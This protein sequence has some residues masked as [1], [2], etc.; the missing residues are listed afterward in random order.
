M[1]RKNDRVPAG[2]F[3]Q[4]IAGDSPSPVATPGAACVN[5]TGMSPPSGKPATVSVIAGAAGA[6]PRCPPGLCAAIG[7]YGSS[8]IMQ[9][10]NPSVGLISTLLR[11]SGWHRGACRCNEYR[12]RPRSDSRLDAVAPRLTS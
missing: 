7:A 5:F 4:L 8:V 9:I 10:T 3:A 6:P 2:A 12:D 1:F 11:R